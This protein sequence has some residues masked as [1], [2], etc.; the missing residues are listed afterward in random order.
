MGKGTNGILSYGQHLLCHGELA[1]HSGRIPLNVQNLP[2]DKAQGNRGAVCP[3]VC[4]I[5][6][7]GTP[8][9]SIEDAR[10]CRKMCVPFLSP[11]FCRTPAIRQIFVTMFAIPWVDNGEKGCVSVRNRRGQPVSGLSDSR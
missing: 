11:G 9:S 4:V 8:F 2:L 3:R 7:C 6:G 5:T 1:P 10:L